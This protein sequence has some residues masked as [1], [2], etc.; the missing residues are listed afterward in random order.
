[1][2]RKIYAFGAKK[3]I[4][5]ENIHAEGLIMGYDIWDKMPLKRSKTSFQLHV[6]HTHVLYTAGIPEFIS[7]INR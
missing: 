3:R 6:H 4:C 1:M 7:S 5:R 2:R